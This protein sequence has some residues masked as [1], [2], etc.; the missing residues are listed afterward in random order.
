MHYMVLR[1]RR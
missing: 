1:L